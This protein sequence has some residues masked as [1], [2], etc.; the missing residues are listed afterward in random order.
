M[1][2]APAE[3]SC[4][5]ISPIGE[6]G[7]NTRERADEIL[8]FVSRPACAEVGF[9]V[10]R[11][12]SIDE[13]GRITRQI[14]QRLVSDDNVG[15]DLTG[16]N[17]NVFYELAIRHAIRKWA[18]HLYEDS[19]EIP[20]DIRDIRAIRVGT[21]ARRA[22]EGKDHLVEA[23]GHVKDAP[24][25]TVETPFTEGVELAVAV[26]ATERDPDAR[27]DRMVVEL[28]QLSDEVRRLQRAENRTVAPSDPEPSV[29]FVHDWPG[30]L[31]YLQRRSA[32]DVSFREIDE[33]GDAVIEWIDARER[34]RRVYLDVLS[35]E[36]GDSGR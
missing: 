4:F 28:A 11:S 13:P 15:A 33:D 6:V 25:E 8:D 20:F 16:L 32:T 1:P 9:S 36:I 19:T 21:S 24:E 27:D 3:L 29:T 14:V 23:L 12:D 31:R 7:S 17:P 22:A 18:I 26:G 2:D 10:E 35:T 5:V 34:T 30:L